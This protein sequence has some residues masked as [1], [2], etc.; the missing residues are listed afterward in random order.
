MNDKV[1]WF[2]KRLPKTDVTEEQ[3]PKRKPRVQ[4]E[5]FAPYLPPAPNVQD[6]LAE[7]QLQSF[8]LDEKEQQIELREVEFQQLRTEKEEELQ[9]LREV[10]EVEFAPEIRVE[11][12]R[13]QIR[14]NQIQQIQE[15]EQRAKRWQKR[16]DDSKKKLGI[17]TWLGEK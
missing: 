7:K 14:E 2:K 17:P 11:I 13:E 6:L 12:D 5:W 9:Q 4:K 10:L 1:E 16:I 3:K 15:L 8:N